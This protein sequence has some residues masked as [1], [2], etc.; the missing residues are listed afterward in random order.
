MFDMLFA[1]PIQFFILAVLAGL[2]RSD[3]DIPEQVT[4]A[5]SMYLMLAIG[6]KG[7]L[8]LRHSPPGELVELWPI[9]LFAVLLSFL[10]PF[11]GFML[12]R[13]T[14]KLPSIDAAAV[15]AHYGSVSVVTFSYAV[16]YMEAH[17]YTYKGYIV[18]LMALMEA[19]AILSGI[20]LARDSQRLQQEERKRMFSPELIRD[21]MFNSSVVLLLGSLIIG[22]TADEAG[23]ARVTPYIVNPFYAV[24]C[25]FLM[26]LGLVS[27]R[28]LHNLRR[29]PFG[30]IAFAFYMPLI[31]ASLALGIAL[32]L[33]MGFPE[34]VLFSVLGASASYIAVPAAMKLALPEANPMY[35]ITSSLVL[36]FPFNLIIGVP[37]YYH[38]V[39]W[40]YGLL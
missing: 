33:G 40:A 18:T 16:S 30:L 27:S 10:L 8:A 35:Y 37:L 21:A 4:K 26:E 19:P 1:P 20:L 28:R 5:M 32:T 36:T 39:K 25:L 22:M 34:A 38:V 17:H 15:A 12:L 9:F 11:V 2:L 24:L 31:G 3:L 23:L 13:G 7:G 14:T 6:L 29:F